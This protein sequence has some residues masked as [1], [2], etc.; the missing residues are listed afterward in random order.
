MRSFLILSLLLIGFG[1]D[2]QIHEASTPVNWTAM[3]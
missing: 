3:R 1:C 2:K